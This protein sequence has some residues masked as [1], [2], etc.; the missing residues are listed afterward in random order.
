MLSVTSD[1]S[2]AKWH[3]GHTTWFFDQ[4]MILKWLPLA[5]E[6]HPEFQLLFNSYYQ[7]VGEFLPKK[8]RSFISRPGLKEILR[9]RKE[10]DHLILELL[11]THSEEAE[12]EILR[13]LE[14]GINHEQQHQELL[15][16]DIKRNF[17]ENPLR[18]A[19]QNGGPHLLVENRVTK[20]I[21]GSWLEF[22]SQLTQIGAPHHSPTFSYDIEKDQH[23]VWLESF[24]ISTN[25]VTNEEYLEFVDAKG[26]E[27]SAGWLSDGWDWVQR[28]SVT[29]P[30]YW[31]KS[32]NNWW[33]FTLEGMKKLPE[34]APVQH[35]SYYEAQ[36]FARFKKL[37]LPTE[38]EWEHAAGNIPSDSSFLNEVPN[39][40]KTLV[41]GFHGQVWEWTQSAFLP[42]PRYQAHEKHLK[43]YNSKFMCNQWVLRGGSNLTPRA[44]Y[45]PTY[46]NFY[47]P[48]DRWQL[49]GMRLATCES[50]SEK[51]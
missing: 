5:Q 38:F 3:L 43:E 26:Y 37:R 31:E 30:L 21:L 48:H 20:P 34:D 18:P 16:M 2:P 39:E 9:Y 50:T 35:L 1:T 10:I 19:F 29:A 13:T 4:F 23:R 32:G 28:N 51:K 45:R 25:R 36:A 27:N 12:P 11:N 40:P 49:S 22:E 6:P 14:L 8:K 44:H 7:S 46:R 15:L 24:K 42:Y 41:S 17:Y 33:Q 47:Y